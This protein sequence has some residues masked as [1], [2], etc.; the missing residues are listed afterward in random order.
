M[1]DTTTGILI[2]L[3]LSLFLSSFLI[4]SITYDKDKTME[5][6]VDIDIGSSENRILNLTSNTTNTGSDISDFLIFDESTPFFPNSKYEYIE[7]LGY[8]FSQ[9]AQIL[10]D[11]IQAT[12]GNYTVKY[13]I[14]NSVE[15]PF[16][17]IVRRTPIFSYNL[18]IN[19]DSEKIRIPNN[20]LPIVS[21]K[22]SN[23]PSLLKRKYFIIETSY[24]PSKEKL[25]LK[26]NNETIFNDIS[27]NPRGNIGKYYY[28][29]FIASGDGIYLSSIEVKQVTPP[30]DILKQTRDIF[31]LIALIII[32][33]IDSVDLWVN[34]VF[35]KT[36]V[37]AIFIAALLAVRGI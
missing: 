9:N 12:N 10:L 15:K 33:N 25:T 26:V 17:I 6:R 22:E 30:T 29:G 14:N 7:G 16:I 36:Q 3:I 34:I 11:N 19:F 1:S 2:G 8:K 13:V 27:V 35:I 32:Y 21:D 20:L 18:D 31:S 4:A 23:Q 37:I 5:N 24:N 28:G